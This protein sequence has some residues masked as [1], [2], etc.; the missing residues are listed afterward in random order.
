MQTALPWYVDSVSFSQCFCLAAASFGTELGPHLLMFLVI[1]GNFQ[2]IIH[3]IRVSSEW[4]FKWSQSLLS[5]ILTQLLVQELRILIFLFFALKLL[6]MYYEWARFYYIYFV[7][8]CAYMYGYCFTPGGQHQ[9]PSVEVPE[10]SCHSSGA[11]HVPEDSDPNRTEEICKSSLI[12]MIDV[13]Y[14]H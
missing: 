5:K 1:L 9:T 11:R 10:C 14:T 13:I 7:Q 2:T 4:R 12:C 6:Y 8:T 3:S